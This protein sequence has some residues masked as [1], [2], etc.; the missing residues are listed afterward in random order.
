MD[1]KT[2]LKR[3]LSDEEI[4]RLM[5]SIK[6]ERTSS[7]ILNTSKISNEEFITNFPKVIKHPFLPNFYYYDKN[8]YDFGKS[9]L[10]DNGVY[11]I[12]DASS[13]LSSFFLDV[14]EN[15]LI[16]DLC[17]APG[18]KTIFKSLTNNNLKIVAN[19]IDYKRALT[20][21]SNIEKLGIKDVTIITH[22]FLNSKEKIENYFDAIILDAPCSGSAMFRKNREFE[23]LWSYNNVLKL[24]S[25]QEK[26]LNK[27]LDMLKPNGNL[28]YSTCSFSYEENEGV[29]DNILKTRDDIEL[30]YLPD[31]DSFFRGKTYKETIYLF[32]FKYKGEGQFI[33]KIKKIDKNNELI[34]KN[35]KDKRNE[36]LDKYILDF[37]KENNLDFKYYKVERNILYGVNY[38]FP[39]PTISKIREGINIAE[40][41]KN[42]LIPSFNLAHYLN[43][44]NSIKLN[45]I[46]K[47]LY[48]KGETFNK[49]VDN[50]KNGYYIVSFNNINLGYIKYVNGV[51]KN[52]Y[53]KGLR[54]R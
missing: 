28:I 19:D 12:M 49:R 8:D 27:A 3:Y 9:Y 29:I 38:S 42:Y 20:L 41:N 22:D 51:M 25:I 16:L 1:F 7:L 33:A 6:E 46:E 50:L 35:I 13:A 15:D 32:P 30:I 21:S 52:L 4:N 37:I 10:F 14:K 5:D 53:P 23:E 43:S 2:H 45:E 26:L 54:K 24:A 48:L 39:F 34:I 11:Y 44:E 17:S 18:G 40:I 47:D 36:K 31:N